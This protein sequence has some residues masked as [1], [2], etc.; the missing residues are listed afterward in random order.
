MCLEISTRFPSQHPQ[1]TSTTWLSN[2]ILEL[3][4]TRHTIFPN[5]MN[6]CFNQSFTSFY[7]FFYASSFRINL[8]SFAR[9]GRHC[10]RTV[11]LLERKAISEKRPKQ[12]LSVIGLG[13]I[14]T[15]TLPSTKR[16]VCQIHLFSE[17]LVRG[18]GW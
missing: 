4:T 18:S 13:T 11:E 16:Q 10:A 12:I 2:N 7:S 1:R 8:R 5:L 14:E 17:W 9:P 15:S 6:F 3:Q